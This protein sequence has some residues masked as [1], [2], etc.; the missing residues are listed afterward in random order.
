MSADDQQVQQLLDQTLAHVDRIRIADN[1]EDQEEVRAAHQ[2][3]ARLFAHGMV[4]R[5]IEDDGGEVPTPESWTEN[6][7]PLAPN[8]G[9]DPKTRA[10]FHRVCGDLNLLHSNDAGL[11]SAKSNYQDALEVLR[12]IDPP[13]ALRCYGRM[14]RASA[15]ASYGAD[16]IEEHAEGLAWAV[17]RARTAEPAVRDE[18]EISLIEAG[19]RLLSFA[20][21]EVADQKLGELLRGVLL[22]LCERDERLPY[23]RAVPWLTV[24]AWANTK[25]LG[26]ERLEPFLKLSGTPDVSHLLLHA[27]DRAVALENGLFYR[28]GG[29]LPPSEYIEATANQVHGLRLKG[30][31]A[32]GHFDKVLA[33]VEQR[34]P[35]LDEYADDSRLN[36]EAVRLRALA[37]L[38]DA[39]TWKTHAGPFISWLEEN[40]G[41]YWWKMY[42]VPAVVTSLQADC[43]QLGDEALSARLAQLAKA[44]DED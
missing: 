22:G 4:D 12:E 9:W 33:L 17:E 29:A 3:F 27:A 19:S 31:E 39:E 43:R 40:A 21:D 41:V 11:N 37:K 30:H 38:G 36:L 28:N 7:E 26:G 6:C 24:G 8:P 44:T 13:A 5:W 35:T 32:L 23:R 15:Y 18:F 16:V 42:G 20:E 34:L 14:L 1:G 25:M 10:R 2:T